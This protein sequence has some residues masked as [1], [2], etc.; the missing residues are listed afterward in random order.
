MTCAM[1]QQLHTCASIN[2]LDGCGKRGSGVSRHTV[3][4]KNR[5]IAVFWHPHE[6]RRHPHERSIVVVVR[7]VSDTS[8]RDGGTI[9]ESQR[10][11]KKS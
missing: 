6:S 4:T 11:V 3:H 1:Q 2:S 8:C 5:A 7:S 10:V 9:K